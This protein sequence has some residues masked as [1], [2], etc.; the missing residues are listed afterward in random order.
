[1][2]TKRILGITFFSA[3]FIIAVSGVMLLTLFIKRDSDAVALPGVS[4]TVQTPGTAEPDELDRVEV[5]T[6]T[7]QD[8]VSTLARPSVYSRDVSV[9]TYWDGGNA[10]YGVKVSVLDGMTSLLTTPPVGVK[11]RIIVAPEKLYIWYLDERTPYIGDLGSSGDGHRSA[12]EWQMIVT[13][14][15]VLGLDESDIIDAGY[16]EYLDDDCIYTVYRSPLLNY[17]TTCY[18]SLDLGLV[19]FA[20]ELDESGRLVYT[21]KVGECAV[22]EVDPSAFILPDGTDLAVV[23]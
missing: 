19:V 1:M 11:K 22:G 3:L 12:D 13:Y 8:V 9:Q 23:G 18:I 14:E 10:E 17:E 6:E 5:T 4:P 2:S 16:T 7:I 15:D 20:E 21:M